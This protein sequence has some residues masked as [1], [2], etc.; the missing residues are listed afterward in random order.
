MKNILP[1]ILCILFLSSYT[2]KIS[3]Q[4]ISTNLNKKST[5]ST[6]EQGAVLRDQS[7]VEYLSEIIFINNKYPLQGEI[8]ILKLLIKTPDTIQKQIDD[9]GTIIDDSDEIWKYLHCEIEVSKT[10]YAFREIDLKSSN[11]T[12]KHKNVI[13]S[14][15]YTLLN[16]KEDFPVSFI[17]NKSEEKNG[18]IT[19]NM[20][21]HP[22]SDDL[23]IFTFRNEKLVELRYFFPC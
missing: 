12:I 15:K 11:F 13:F 16:F 20:F 23:Y 19:I 3:S 21:S 6:I 14:K 4:E 7:E 22:L 5:S 9:C 18:I 1:L 10:E 2:T 17:K 8:N